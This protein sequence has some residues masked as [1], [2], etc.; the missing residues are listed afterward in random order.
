MDLTGK[1]LEDRLYLL[2]QGFLLLVDRIMPRNPEEITSEDDLRTVEFDSF[3]D[4]FVHPFD[5]SVEVGGENEGRSHWRFIVQKI[6]KVPR[7]DAM[8]ALKASIDSL[9]FAEGELGDAMV[10]GLFPKLNMEDWIHAMIENVP[11]GHIITFG[12]IA[13]A[14]GTKWASRAVGEV[15]SRI[16][17]PTHRIVYA[18][19]RIPPGSSDELSNEIKLK[20][21]GERYFV[22]DLPLS[23]FETDTKPLQLLS[24]LQTRM[25]QLL[26]KVDD[27]AVRSVAGMDISSKDELNVAGLSAMKNDGT[28]IDE[29]WFKGVPG[30]PYIPGLLFYREA[31]LLL[32]LLSMAKDNGIIDDDTLCVMDGNGTLHPRRMGIACQVGVSSGLMTCGVAKK[33]LIGNVEDPKEAENGLFLSDITDNNEKIGSALS[34]MDRSKPVYLSRGHRIDQRSVDRIIAGL[35]WTRIPEPTKRAHALS[36]DVR[37]SEAPP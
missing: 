5:I 1:S 11:K 21:V 36:N 19:G 25:K 34:G 35:R 18:D 30:I 3:F 22:A 24:D 2:F 8:A 27:P 23:I 26:V 28:P 12:Q 20:K 4:Q 37:R 15:I 33:L 9:P 31:P 6:I 16:D 14:L 29:I 7:Q 10:E 13:E 17:G 32:P